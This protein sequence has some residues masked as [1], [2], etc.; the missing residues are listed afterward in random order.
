MNSKSIWRDNYAFTNFSTWTFVLKNFFFIKS[1]NKHIDCDTD[2]LFCGILQ[3]EMSNV[4]HDISWRSRCK[5][6][7][8]RSSN[9]GLVKDGMHRNSITF[10]LKRIKFWPNLSVVCHFTFNAFDS[11]ESN[12]SKKLYFREWFLYLL[13][14]FPVNFRIQATSSWE[15][16]WQTLQNFSPWLTQDLLLHTLFIVTF[17]QTETKFTVETCFF[18]RI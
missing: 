17:P 6:V 1:G 3:C 9:I 4:S 10:N 5:Q 13:Q 16:N 12:F 14:K 2:D 11:L 7:S 8:V 18:S 15:L